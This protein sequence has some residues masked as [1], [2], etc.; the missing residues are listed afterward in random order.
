MKE[1]F[2]AAK[3]EQEKGAPLNP[4]DEL[5]NTIFY[6]SAQDV[7]NLKCPQEDGEFNDG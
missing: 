6:G 7:E 1:A 3:I 4:W 2:Y 5:D